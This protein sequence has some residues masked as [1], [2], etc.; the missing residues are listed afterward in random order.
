MLE[1]QIPQNS[2]IEGDQILEL[3]FPSSCLIVL[4]KRNGKFITPYGETELKAEDDFDG[5]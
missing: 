2:I 4:V 5:K 1:F 3:G